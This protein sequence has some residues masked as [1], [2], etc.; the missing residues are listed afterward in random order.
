MLI[1]NVFPMSSFPCLSD[2]ACLLALSRWNDSL[3]WALLCPCLVE[4]QRRPGLLLGP[5]LQTTNSKPVLCVS[6]PTVLP[7]ESAV[8]VGLISQ[9]KW[10]IVC[11]EHL[12]QPVLAHGSQGLALAR[13]L[14]ISWEA[15]R[16]SYTGRLLNG[17]S[18]K[19]PT[20]MCLGLSL[21]FSID[22]SFIQQTLAFSL[23]SARTIH[24]RHISKPTISVIFSHC[25]LPGLFWLVVWL[26]FIFPGSLLPWACTFVPD[27]DCSRTYLLWETA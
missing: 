7:K 27:G 8:D 9:E 12:R 13:H 23:C 5:D 16:S 4:S 2:P 1:W 17:G 3:S 15:S 21:S 20:P 25:P 14:C 26:P 6:N 22:S 10:W 19:E 18:R 11:V 24:H